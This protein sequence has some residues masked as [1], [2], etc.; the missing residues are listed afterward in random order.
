MHSSTNPLKSKLGLSLGLSC[1]LVG[2]AGSA[3]GATIVW[4]AATGEYNVPAN[5][6][7]DQ[8]PTTGDQG[9]I[10]NGGTAVIDATQGVQQ[11]GSFVLGA[12][13]NDTGTLRITGGGLTTTSSDLRIGGNGN[14]TAGNGA[15]T[16]EQSGGDI[17]LNA[18]NVNVGLGAAA[19]PGDG[20]YTLSGGTMTVSSGFI[21]AVGNNGNGTVNQSGGSIFVRGAG[22]ANPT[23]TTVV[24]LGRQTTGNASGSYTLS[25]GD[26]T[27]ANF[28]FGRQAQTSTNPST[29]T[30]TLTGSGKLTTGTISIGNTSANATNTFN[31]TGGTLT[32]NN[33]NLPLV[34]NGGT[35]SPAAL[36]FGTTNAAGTDP[37]PS[38]A[39]GTLASPV[40]TTTFGTTAV[41]I[42]Y[43]QTAGTLAIDIA[44]TGGA[45]QPGGFDFVNVTGVANLAGTVAVDELNG[46][47]PAP[48]STFDVLTA[49]DIMGT[50]V[51]SGT[52]PGGN[53]YST[54]IEPGGNGEVLRLTVVPEPAAVGLLG[55]ATTGLL[56]RR[57]RRPA[58][59]G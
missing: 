31:F 37:A 22:Q 7:P 49:L 45:G 51:P 57:R 16:L 26:L 48:G 9:Q 47:D 11:V 12:T 13:L 58:G 24:Q 8:V 4:D 39:A 1:V 36:R 3:S 56:G 33:V 38:T 20:T 27:V 17:L 53:A 44:G 2:V 55:L 40:G 21:I 35:L 59:R 54:S 28:Q 50:L 52:T 34:N 14:A 25:G 18:G 10:N 30:L 29:N 43:T 42:N 5:W 6:N 19:D 23:L 41:P 15:G 46:F 32:A